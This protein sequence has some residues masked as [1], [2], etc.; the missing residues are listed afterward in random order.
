MEASSSIELQVTVVSAAPDHFVFRYRARN[1]WTRD[2]YLF[3]R[4][5]D[6]DPTGRRKVDPNRVY[7]MV[8]G[9]VL[10][11]S[12]QLFDVPETLDVEFP[13]VPYLTRLAPGAA[14]EEEIRLS[15]PARETYPYASSRAQRQP[16]EK[17]V[18]EQFVF[19]LGYFHAREASWVRPIQIDGQELLATDYGFASQT[20]QAVASP[21]QRVRTECLVLADPRR[22]ARG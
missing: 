10:N 19:T 7:V 22:R 21:A 17:R 14:F 9:S 4:L 6:T 15:L 1:A 8:E 5:F 2:L 12:K 18:C 11:A 16:G 3:N 20:R 13:E